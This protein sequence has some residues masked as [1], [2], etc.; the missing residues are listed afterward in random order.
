MWKMLVPVN[1]VDMPA[2][3]WAEMRSNGRSSLLARHR[4]A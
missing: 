2:E 1:L 4:F 3:L